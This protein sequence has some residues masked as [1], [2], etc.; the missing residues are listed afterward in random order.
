[1]RARRGRLLAAL[2][3]F[4]LVP[5]ANAFAGANSAGTPATG[6]RERVRIEDN[7]YEPRE[8]T[9]RRGDKVTWLWRGENSHNVTFI[10]VPHGA[11]KKG[12]DTRRTGRWTRT[13]WKRG[14]YKYVCTVHYGQRGS[15]EVR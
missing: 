5:L 10:N 11:S 8:L 12:A 4:A 3:V 14:L 9:I 6:K 1:M 13:F 7:F 15:V 2:L